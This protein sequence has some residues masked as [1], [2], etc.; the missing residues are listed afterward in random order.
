MDGSHLEQIRLA[1][2]ARAM[3]WMPAGAR[4]L[5]IGAG[6]GWQARRLA[7]AGFDVTAIDVADS[8]YR[9]A[10]VWPIIDYDGRR[11][12]AEDA[13][14]DV[15]FSSNVLEHVDD[16]RCFL[17]ETARV[18]RPGGR[19]VHLVPSATWRLWT[20]LTHYPYVI[21]RLIALTAPR[22]ADSCCEGAQGEGAASGGGRASMLR[23]VLWSQRHGETGNALTELYF[24]SRRR[25]RR[26]FDETGWT[27]DAV[28]GNE[29]FYSGYS[30]IG[31]SLSIEARSRLSRYL[32]SSC[33]LFVLSRADVGGSL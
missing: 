13:S 29:L 17:P 33:H 24:F 5:E 26:L 18:L 19:A 3:A 12:P 31:G 22:T 27:V 15:V 25:W 32:G 7:A 1:E 14:F 4:V 6:T 23:K 2:L 16:V 9:R 28:G 8:N 11:I 20:S 30:I 21:G 10:R